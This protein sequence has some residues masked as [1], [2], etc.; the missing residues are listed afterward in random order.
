LVFR[1]IATFVRFG[2]I[3]LK[4][5]RKVPLLVITKKS[6]VVL[7]RLGLEVI[8]GLGVVTRGSIRSRVVFRCL[9]GVVLGVS[10]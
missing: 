6:S 3:I 10:L 7:A 2:T 9:S 1:C 5:K 4:L 8:R